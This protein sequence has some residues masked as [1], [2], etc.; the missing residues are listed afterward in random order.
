[1]SDN[2]KIT[3]TNVDDVET[4]IKKIAKDELNVKGKGY[5][6]TETGVRGIFIF[7]EGSPDQAIDLILSD[8]E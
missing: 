7:I 5:V 6:N 2:I 4:F 1:M 3:T 8:E